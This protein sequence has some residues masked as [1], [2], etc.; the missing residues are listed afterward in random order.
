MSEESSIIFYPW[1]L[2]DN[3]ADSEDQTPPDKVN[4]IPQADEIPRYTAV[5]RI[6]SLGKD[7]LK[8][9]RL[10]LSDSHFEMAVFFKGN[11]SI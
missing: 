10:G 11:S 2:A 9:K 4:K 5:A 8:S 1:L 7:N 3:I 6:F